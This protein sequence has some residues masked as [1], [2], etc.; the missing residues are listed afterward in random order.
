M[1]E[2][3]KKYTTEFCKPNKTLKYC[4]FPLFPVQGTARKL[5]TT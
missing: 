5:K 3:H 1:L 2:R 4:Q